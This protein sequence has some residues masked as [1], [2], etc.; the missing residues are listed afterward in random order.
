MTRMQQLSRRFRVFFLLVLGAI[1]LLSALIWL[2]LDLVL[3]GRLGPFPGSLGIDPGLV[4]GPVTGEMKLLGFLVF[5]L[6]GSLQMAAMWHLARLFGEFAR[7]ELF[8]AT[9]VGLLSRTGWVLLAAQVAGVVSG[10]LT[11]LVLTM[12]NPAGQHMI[13][14]SL[15]GS[16][17]MGGCLGLALVFASRVLDEARLLREADALTI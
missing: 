17:I 14:A 9:T 16:E 4:R 8:S 1:P 2:N 13:S 15:S 5:M 3:S 10:S 11:T 12:H 7:G 6:P